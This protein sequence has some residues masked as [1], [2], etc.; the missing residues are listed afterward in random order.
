M[1]GLLEINGLTRRFGDL[2]A[3]DGLSFSVPAGQVVGFL[4]PNGA[5][6]TTTMR[7]IFGLTDL[8]SGGVKWNGTS[9]GQAQRRRFG[10]MP[11]E[12]GLYPAMKIGEQLQYLGRLHGMGAVEAQAAA[13][14]WLERMDLANRVDGKVED[15]SHGNQQRVQL[16]A[17]LMHSPELLILDE[18]LAGLDPG[19]I[20]TI[21]GVL[22]EQARAGCCVIFSS[23]QLDQVEDLCDS[24][25]IIDHG[26][27]IVTG[28]VDQLATSGQ[29]RLVVRVEGDR[30]GAW[31]AGLKGVTISEVGGGEVRLI[32][33]KS[34][35]S[36]V[37]LKAAM[38][39]GTVTEFVFARS[40]L[41]EVFRE[42]LS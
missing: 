15:L 41:S 29:R 25:I 18:P 4:G 6:K 20:D 2:T 26:R 12:R 19:G 37:V 40:R 33:E 11:E 27:L 14:T 8:D 5:G 31:A 42:A 34:V 28:T 10:Y 22:V 13:M 36:D 24:V 3:L 23:H 30:K 17:A 16:A 32:L 7:A 39:A 38:A 21:G 1:S 35:D 9:V